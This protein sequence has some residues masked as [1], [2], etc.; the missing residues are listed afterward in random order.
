M[1]ISELKLIFTLIILI[2]QYWKLS[3]IKRFIPKKRFYP[4]PKKWNLLIILIKQRTKRT[5]S[6]A[7]IEV[8][9]NK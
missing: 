6:V 3:K 1:D 9:K 4:K 7:E 8:N 2:R 5:K